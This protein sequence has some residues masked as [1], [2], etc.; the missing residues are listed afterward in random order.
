MTEKLGTLEDLPQDYRDDMANAGVAPL[1]PMMRN[2]LPHD[3]PNPVTKPGYCGN[4]G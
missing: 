2:V 1:W 4:S 3:A